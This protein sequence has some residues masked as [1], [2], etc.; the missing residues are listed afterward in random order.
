MEFHHVSVLLHETIDGLNINPNGIYVDGT[1]GGGG[2]SREILKSLDGG[3]LI[4]FDRDETAIGVCR[5]R[6]SEFGDRVEFVNRNFFEIKKVLRELGIDTI[7]G[8]VLD[9]G[10]S[11]HQLDTAERGF[12][13]QHDAPL[14]M[15]MN[16]RDTLTAK[17]VVNTYTKEQLADI[18]FRYGEDRW[19]KRIAEFIVAE[20]E[21]EEILTT[22]RLVEAIKKAVPKGA[23]QDG[24][25]PAKRTFQAIRIEVNSE[26]AGLEQAVRDFIDVLAPGGRLSIITFHSLED[27]IVK[28]V[29]A[30]CAK[31]CIC[32]PEIPV[33]ICGKKPLGKVITRKAI[34]ASDQELEENPRA[35]SAH[36]R[37]FEKK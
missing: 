4:G 6:L 3:K 14:D 29:Y 15:R 12:S 1:M 8:A 13:Y 34:A 19:A 17:D 20:R 10:V 18:I 26:L 28:T 24:P 25:H 22:G 7:D 21:K 35:R 32:P 37:I 9:L 36:L 30:E 5:E 23:R 16:R 11:S 2:H 33:C 27:R 31:G